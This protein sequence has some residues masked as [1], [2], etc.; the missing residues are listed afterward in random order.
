MC[1]SMCV[2]LLVVLQVN[3]IRAKLNVC[4]VYLEVILHWDVCLTL[5]VCGCVCVC[6]T[7]ICYYY[8]RAWCVF[9]FRLN[10]Q[11]AQQIILSNQERNSL[12]SLWTVTVS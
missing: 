11:F 12:G 3:F 1:V 4:S 10:E 5:C 6:C 9:R 7:C 2:C 8:C